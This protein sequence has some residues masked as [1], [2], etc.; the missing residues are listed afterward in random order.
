MLDAA[1]WLPRRRATPIN[2]YK[3][4]T[5]NKGA[6]YGAHE[7]YLMP[8]STPFG[9]IVRH[10]TPFFVSRQVV[11]GVRPGRDRPGRAR[12]R[13]PAQPARRLLRGRGRARDDAQAA[14]HQHPRRAARRPGEVPPAP[15]DHRRRQPRRDLDVP[16]GR[17]DLAGAGDDRGPASSPP[18]SASTA[19]SRRCGPSRTTRRCASRSRCSDGRTA[20]RAPAAGGVPRAGPQVRRRPARLRRRRPDRRRARPLG[21]GAR[22]ARS[23]TRCCAPASSTGSPSSSC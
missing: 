8:R 20:D 1:G 11:C 4:N 13:L 18:T 5:D 14:D 15:R 16:Q 17:H 6:S 23:R 2:L 12:A 3:N 21:V 10:L 22:P 19:R 9:D 7:N